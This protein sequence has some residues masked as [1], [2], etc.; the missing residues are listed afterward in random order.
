MALNLWFNWWCALGFGLVVLGARA[1]DQVRFESI[2]AGENR[3]EN[4]VVRSK[5][6][7]SLIVTH[8]GGAGSDPLARLA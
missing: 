4:V 7:S 1:S 6:A 5:N 2:E 8:S 3:Y